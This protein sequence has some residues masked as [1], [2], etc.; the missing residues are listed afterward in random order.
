MTKSD[1][2]AKPNQRIRILVVGQTP[3]PFTGQTVMI[4]RMLEGRYDNAELYHVRMAFSSEIDDVGRF[5]LKKLFHIVRL[6]LQIAWSRLRLRTNVLYYPPAG[7]NAIPI[8]RDV[9]ILCC[10]RWMFSQTAFH[11]HAG[12]LSE[13][14]ERL[15]VVPRALSR[16]SYSKPDLCIRLS[17]ETPPDCSVL[18]ARHSVIVPY[19][20]EDLAKR[21]ALR[22]AETTR[23]NRVRLLF[24]GVILESKGVL[25]L[26][27]ACR[28]LRARRLDFELS[29][30]GGFRD[31]DFER[32]V[33]ALVSEYDL[34][35]QVHFTG[36]LTGSEKADVFEQADIFCFPSHYEAEALPVVLIEAMEFGLPILASNWRGI[37]SLVT[38][39]E[40][41]FL[42]PP[43]DPEAAA[44]A[45]GKMI[46]DP[47]LRLR[48]GRS[49]RERYEQRHTLEQFHLNLDQ[50]FGALL[51]R[52][53]DSDASR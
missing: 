37:P 34:S 14:L 45:L 9:F 22:N 16:W 17:D 7:P 38:D 36:I 41:G 6:V 11:F 33:R 30:V 29:I 5:Q 49:G 23:S 31:R 18:K 46:A 13:F 24:V 3:P 4:Q 35:S 42:V 40:N 10:T 20:I 51:T 26:L 12:G 15:S 21:P 27:S 2:A 25:T 8:S 47:E 32:R 53:R 44:A 19:G 43:K 50:A 28:T 48:L 39:G 1:S 52:N